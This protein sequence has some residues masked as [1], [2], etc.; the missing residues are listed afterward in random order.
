MGQTEHLRDIQGKDT[1]ALLTEMRSRLTNRISRKCQ[2]IFLE[3][4]ERWIDGWLDS[5]LDGWK[6]GRLKK[7][8]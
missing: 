7:Q 3:K 1:C 5:S 4:R 2:A 6:D 8:T